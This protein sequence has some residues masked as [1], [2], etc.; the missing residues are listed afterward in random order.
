MSPRFSPLKINSSMNIRP[1]YSY[2]ND[3]Q[4]PEFPD[5]KPIII[6]DGYCAL[7]SGWAQ[8]V[9]RH[10]K[11]GMYRLLAAQNPLG[12]ALYIHYGLD[13][14]HYETNILM[15]EGVVWLK[16]EGSIRMAE[17]LGFPWRMA[18]LFRLLPLRIRDAL[19]SWVA[20][21]RFAWFGRRET[22]YVPNED[23]KNRFLG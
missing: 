9:L 7:C 22:C 2:R 20:C 16:S 15:A 12:K 21:N 23:Y 17:G 19:Y 1:A 14:A 3:P 11:S 6:F 18:A 10:D 4:I 5:D 13:P 8:F